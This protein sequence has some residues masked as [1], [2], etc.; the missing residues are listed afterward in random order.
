MTTEGRSRGAAALLAAFE[1]PEQLTEQSGLLEAGLRVGAASSPSLHQLSQQS[2][3]AHVQNAHSDD[4]ADDAALRPPDP[5]EGAHEELRVVLRA[6]TA[7]RAAR[8]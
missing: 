1:P 5:A 8:G 2:N 6:A 3:A 4:D 7:V